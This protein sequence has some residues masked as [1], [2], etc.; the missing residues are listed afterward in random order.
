MVPGDEISGDEDDDE[1]DEEEEVEWALSVN[2][3]S[4]NGNCFMHNVRL[5]IDNA[6]L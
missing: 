3:A 2:R 1:G 6:K 5:M 4:K